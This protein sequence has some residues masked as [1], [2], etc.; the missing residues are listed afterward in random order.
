MT[1]GAGNK[2]SAADYNNVRNTFLN[3]L[4]TGSGNAGYGQTPNSSAVGSGVKV[5]ESDWDKLRRDI[6]RIATHQG[7]SIIALPDVPLGGKIT[8]AP[9]VTYS[10]VYTTLFNNRFN[11]AVGQYSD[12]LMTESTRTAGWN[13]TISH[14]FNINF[15]SYDNARYFFNSGGNIRIRPTYTKDSA[16]TLNNDW[17]SLIS[18]VPTLVFNYQQTSSN[19]VGGTQLSPIGFYSLPTG[20]T[21]I[22][23]RTGGLIS[24]AAT[25]A[26]NDYT[27]RVYGNAASPSIIYF[28]CEFKD[29]KTRPDPLWPQGDENVT[30]TVR[31]TVRM[32]R[33]TETSTGDSVVIPVPSTSVTAN[34]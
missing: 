29:D 32:F 33:P 26:V 1:V 31:N 27:V 24:G 34:L 7:T 11:I 9:L 21:Q 19:A 15:G 14:Y 3:I 6:Q 12:E 18:G 10:T 5:K 8:S 13:G 4:G 23:T 28:E 25:Y 30:G 22:Y 17:E 2:V 20:A 16:T